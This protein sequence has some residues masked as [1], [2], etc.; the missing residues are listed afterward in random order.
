MKTRIVTISREYGSGGRA[1]GQ[2]L[3]ARLGIACYDQ[4]L[5]G[6]IAMETG[7]A[8]E[9]I[10]KRGEDAPRGA[11][12][13]GVFAGKDF[14]GLSIQDELWNAQ[15]KVILSLAER[16]PCVIVGRCADYILRER[17]DCLT[18]FIHADIRVRAKRIVEEYGEKPDNPEKRLR[19]KDKRRAAYYQVYTDQVWG[20][21]HHYHLM[22]NSG[23]LALS[24][25]WTCWLACTGRI[26]THNAPVR[27][28][29]PGA[30]RSG[31]FLTGVRRLKFGYRWGILSQFRKLLLLS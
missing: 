21:P 2:Q 27:P 31:G 3:A 8:R 14:Y 28:S 4:A 30:A 25:V 18:A 15:R 5:I 23:V 7:F 26:S 13:G 20:D 1:V 22:L 11:W 17:E 9:Y 29:A 12:L 24:A 19:D 6:K 16:E 10:S